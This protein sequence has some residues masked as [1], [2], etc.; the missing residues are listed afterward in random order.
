[1][2]LPLAA[3]LGSLGAW[4]MYC[5]TRSAPATGGGIATVLLLLPAGVV[6]DMKAQHPIFEVRSS[7]E[8]NAPAERVWK[9]VVSFP[10]L[11]EPDE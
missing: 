5:A 3:P 11:P 10:E 1:M 8:I 2:A 6:R 9:Y 7:V 4:L